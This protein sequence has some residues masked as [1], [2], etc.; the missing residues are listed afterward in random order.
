MKN[1]KKIFIYLSTLMLAGIKPVLATVSRPGG[2][3]GLDSIF[4]LL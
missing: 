2:T 3:F 1:G 4:N